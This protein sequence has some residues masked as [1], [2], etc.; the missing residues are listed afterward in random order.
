MAQVRNPGS[1]ES[2]RT[3]RCGGVTAAALALVAAWETLALR[4][5]EDRRASARA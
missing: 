2:S 3:A 5:A 4:L 1:T